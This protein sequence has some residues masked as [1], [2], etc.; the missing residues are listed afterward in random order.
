MND[1]AHLKPYIQPTRQL[2]EISIGFTHWLGQKQVAIHRYPHYNQI[3]LGRFPMSVID[4]YTIRT[5]L[6]SPKKNK[7]KEVNPLIKDIKGKEMVIS[8]SN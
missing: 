8:N 3:A 4:D 6:N 7:I 2:G 5:I 1:L